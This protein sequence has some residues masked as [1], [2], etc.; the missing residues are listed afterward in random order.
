[1]TGMREARPRPRSA[2]C[3]AFTSDAAQPDVELMRNAREPRA[4]TRTRSA[5]AY[6]ESALVLALFVAPAAAAQIAP[7]TD[8]TPPVDAAAQQPAK[9]EPAAA[10]LTLRTRL[11]F[12]TAG[13]GESKPTALLA[14]DIDGDG[15][16]ELIA[17]TRGKGSVQIW[18]G[19]ESALAPYPEPLVLP[20]GDY[21]LGPVF[22]GGSSNV[23]KTGALPIVVAPRAT[24]AEIDVVDVRVL[25][26]AA[27][28]PERAIVRRI[29][30]ERRPRV[31]ASGD[32][33]HDGT[34][35]IAIVTID[36]EL[37][38][39]GASG[40]V[41][42]VSL[43]DPEI[44]VPLAT[45]LHFASDGS[46]LAIAFQGTRR[47]EWWSAQVQA[48]G[49]FAF[50]R[51]AVARLDGLPRDI[52]ELDV[53][54]DG[55]AELVVVG[56]DDSVWMFGMN[57]PG[58]IAAGLSALPMPFTTGAIPIDVSHHARASGGG[59]DL[60]VVSLLG[61]TFSR[62]RAAPEGFHALDD[63]YAGQSPHSGA[64][65]DF[66]GD[67]RI[68]V[69]I[70]NTDAGRVSVLFADENGRPVQAHF[71]MTDRTPHSLAAGD[72]DGDGYKEVLVLNAADGTLSI[73][74]NEHGV[75]AD[76][77][78]QTL[79]K[80]ADSV[81]LADLDGDGRLEG[82]F[83]AQRAK[84]AAVTVLFGSKGQLFE[85]AAFAPIP[86]SEGPPSP[87][88]RD[89]LLRDFDGD[90]RIDVLATDPQHDH[91]VFLHN[92]T[93]SGGELAFDA[94]VDVDSPSGP[95]GL[96][97]LSA[98]SEVAVAL[99]GPGARLGV[100]ILR[101]ETDGAGK[102]AWREIASIPTGL[103]PLGLASGDL[104]GDGQSDLAVLVTEKNVDSPCWVMPCLRQTD[105]S[106]R[107]LAPFPVGFRPYR[108]ASGDLDGDGRAEILVSA[109][110]SHHVE[111]WLTRGGDPLRFERTAD[112]GLHGGCLDVLLADLDNDGRPEVIVADGFSTDVGVVTIR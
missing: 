19:L 6:L 8:P 55:D 71:S 112:L 108:V 10:K 43:V 94:P 39:F 57:A 64:L 24:P 88:T 23:P 15:R 34:P 66:D 98:P 68:D 105:G 12:P 33:G 83:V 107:P 61:L 60:L 99:C 59:S 69:A 62:Y 86:I 42:R 46:G 45:A 49:G 22:L 16:D 7:A 48:G 38:V 75:L 18:R 21:P 47:V 35:E 78:R 63:A 28:E 17:T 110:N 58:G 100:S 41:A 70:A 1:M 44:G 77:R 102:S 5:R 32:L 52:D 56:G 2:K 96:A 40:A 79:A 73:A 87:G 13:A 53:D 54:A 111:L 76:A 84:D 50:Q 91:V 104:D 92:K 25:L 82:V 67:G 29:P 85:R 37:E 65:G 103:T 106:W 93:P 4:D 51:R 27:G 101:L 81:R 74:K 80:S 89:L 36:D 109:Q 30:L 11:E 95:G 31:L 9:A 3:A 20:I 14:C 97:A 90:G 72:L 26:A